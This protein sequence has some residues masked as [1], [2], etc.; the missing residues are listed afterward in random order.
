VGNDLSGGKL[1]RVLKD[2]GLT[3]FVTVT[4]YIDDRRM[5]EELAQAT[6][7]VVP[8]MLEGFGLIAAEAMIAGTCVV[9]SDAPGLRSIVRDGETGLVFRSGDSTECAKAVAR[10]LDDRALRHA[11]EQQARR[12]GLKRFHLKERAMD[13]H[14]VFER[15]T[16]Q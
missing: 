7:L 4:G 3:D 16:A 8:S 10:I 12:E 11:L 2:E 13:L 5:Y 9:A 14:R 1:R 6:V 15:V